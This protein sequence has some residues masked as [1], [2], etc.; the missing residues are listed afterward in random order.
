MAALDVDLGFDPESF[1]PKTTRLVV[2]V[3]GPAGVGKS[4]MA[5]SLADAGLGRLCVIGTEGKTR[6]LP[7]YGQGRFDAYEVP[8]D[9]L[10]PFVR[11]AI[12]KGKKEKGWNCFVLDSWG[13]YFGRHYADLVEA[14][15]SKTGDPGA[16]PTSDQLQAE[17]VQLQR[18]L[19]ALCNESDASVVITDPV[20]KGDDEAAEGEVGRLLPITLGGLEIYTDLVLDASL[21][22]DGLSVKRVFRV[23]KSNSPAFR[24]GMEF[25]NPTFA[26][27][28]D[29][30]RTE[31]AWDDTTT[32]SVP[33]EP[34]P[35]MLDDL[36]F[37]TE[38]QPEQEQAL[39]NLIRKAEE[40]GFTRAD[41]VT[42]ARAYC[43][44]KADLDTLTAR[45]VSV[46]DKRMS[47]TIEKKRLG[48][49][50]LAAHDTPA[51]AASAR[52]HA[53]RKAP[54]AD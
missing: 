15:R 32:M 47:L 16:L 37:M 17:Q 31:G 36:D 45:D 9:K 25:D 35:P 23:V 11:W 48:G 13:Q 8:H 28:V 26:T 33:V 46:L 4:H 43:N 27:L 44:G 29:H 22:M 52:G 24:N 38:K 6:L 49:Q 34:D 1:R 3:R 40:H 19:R 2:A 14:V 21:R 50:T 10:L 30:L 5:A 7:G 18:V 39:S 53:A 54:I 20:G 51:T 42:A 41:L 12:T